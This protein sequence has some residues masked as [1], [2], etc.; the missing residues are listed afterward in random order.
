MILAAGMRDPLGDGEFVLPDRLADDRAPGAGRAQGGQIGEGGDPARGLE[1]DRRDSAATSP[2]SASRLGPLSIPSREMSVTSK[3]RTAGKSPSTSSRS[4]PDPR[5]QPWVATSAAPSSIRTSSASV[6]RSGPIV[7]EHGGDGRGVG[8]GQAADDD[9]RH[10]RLEQRLDMRAR[11]DPAGDL[12]PQRRVAGERGEQVMLARRPGARAVEVDEMR[13][14]RAA[15]GEVGKRGGGV[16]RIDCLA[17]E[18]AL[19]EPHAT[20][21]DKVD[22]GKQDHDARNALRKDAP[23]ADERSGWNCAPHRWPWRTA[24]GIGRP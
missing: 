18:I 19:R 10:P 22:G 24:A 1:F 12:E 21:A 16:V 11:A 4:R 7:V 6:M 23:A 13:F 2:A 17:R 8:Q 9:A 15:R 5:S 14:L 20:A 3:W